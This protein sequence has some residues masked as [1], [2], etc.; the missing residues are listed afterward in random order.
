MIIVVP[1]I[2]QADLHS[3]ISQYTAIMWREMEIL[4]HGKS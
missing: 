1:E 4:T 3:G 2:A